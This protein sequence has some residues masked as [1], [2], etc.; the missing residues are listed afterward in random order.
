MTTTLQI[1]VEKDLKEDVDALFESL[2]CDLSTAVR[3]FFHA[4]LKEH[5]LPFKVRQPRYNRATI[6]AMLDSRDP[7]KLIGPF[8]SAEEAI[9]AMLA[10][11]EEA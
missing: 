3:M 2:G 1:R 6:Q 10:D 5:G 11:D 4:A 9:N 8:S 7:S